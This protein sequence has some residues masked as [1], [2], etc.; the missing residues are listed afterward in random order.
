MS[1]NVRKFIFIVIF[2]TS[3]V[4]YSWSI[5]LLPPIVLILPIVQVE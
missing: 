1:A 4:V 5:S 3:D 2:D